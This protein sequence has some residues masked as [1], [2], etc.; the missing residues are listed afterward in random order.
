MAKRK[1][2]RREFDWRSYT[3]PAR[4]LTPAQECSFVDG[5]LA[6]LLHWAQSNDSVRFEIRSRQAAIYHAGTLLLRIRGAEA[7]FVG[8][9]DEN[10]RLPKEE[11]SGAERLETWPLSSDAEV[12]AVLVELA[13]LRDRNE[14]GGADAPLSERGALHAFAAANDGL[15][16]DRSRYIIADT[17]FQYG[18]RRFDFVGMRRAEGVGGIAGFTTPRLVFGQLKSDGRSLAGS[19]GL[20]AH[21]ADFAD[22]AQALGGAHL[23]AAR[24]EL[25]DLVQQK[26]RLGLMD[27]GIPFR[28]FPEDDPEYL[29]VFSGHDLAS[30]AL[31]APLAEMHDK[32]VA[33]HCRPELLRFVGLPAVDCEGV[34]PLWLGSEEASSYREFKS[35]RKRL[36]TTQTDST[37]AKEM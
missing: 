37:P 13:A 10:V 24:T 8:E 36:R 2:S 18:K 15:L 6:P 17:E 21:A 35:R 16:G 26:L 19:S 34:S 20:V 7:P 28:H 3:K 30:E 11:R 32:L 33:R 12:G 4:L 14:P 31:D 22:F 5:L 9:I 25:D 27:A 1:P 23:A 29:L